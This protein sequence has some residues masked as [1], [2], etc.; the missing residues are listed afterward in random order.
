MAGTI[1][2]RTVLLTSA[3]SAHGDALYATISHVYRPVFQRHIYSLT[4]GQLPLLLH[5]ARSVG[6]DAVFCISLYEKL[7][8]NEVL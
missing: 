4:K 6:S 2:Y 8:M 5:T 3:L 1:G 7:E